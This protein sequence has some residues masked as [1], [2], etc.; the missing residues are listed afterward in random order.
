MSDTRPSLTNFIRTIILLIGLADLT[1]KARTDLRSHTNAVSDLHGRDL[2][3]NFDRFADDFMTDADRKGTLAP[4]AV[5]GVDIRAADAAGFNLYVD[6]AGFERF[7]FELKNCYELDRELE[8]EVGMRVS[9]RVE[10]D[11]VKVS[12]EWWSSGI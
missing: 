1:L 2:V 9:R 5:N 6:V 10:E 8:G 11:G 4:A 12:A 7:R 3:P